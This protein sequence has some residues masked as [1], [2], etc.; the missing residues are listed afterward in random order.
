[1]DVGTEARHDRGHV[2]HVRGLSAASRALDRFPTARDESR[3]P[4][5]DP[6]H[7][8]A[9]R[10]SLRTVGELASPAT[11][12]AP[13]RG[14]T[15]TGLL[16]APHAHGLGR[17]LHS[18]VRLLHVRPSSDRARASG[19]TV[20]PNVGFIAAAFAIVWGALLAY[21]VSLRARSA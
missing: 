16:D 12:R 5:R 9:D 1:V 8:R 19:A 17:C 13:G 10:P 14:R 18:R 4:W 20:D 21:L 3:H 2:R 6:R 11:D 7:R 15:G